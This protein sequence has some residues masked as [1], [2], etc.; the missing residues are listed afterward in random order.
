MWLTQNYGNIIW[1]VD[2]LI[3]NE[4]VIFETSKH[5][6][7]AV[8]PSGD[9]TKIWRGE[10]KRETPLNQ[11][12]DDGGLLVWVGKRK[13]YVKSLVA[14]TFMPDQYGRGD[15]IKHINGNIEDCSVDNLLI[16]KRD[17]S[18]DN[19]SYT[20]VRVDGVEYKS[21]A[22][23]ERALFVSHGYLSKY[24]KGQVSGKIIEGRKVE[25]VGE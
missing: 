1:G 19:R 10:I 4:R 24:F 23:A 18:L 7:Y 14:N 25:L 9:V 12:V 2:G 6:K 11:Y 16:E 22:A 15:V 21:I 3:E 5:Y 8:Y 20:K 17:F 13:L